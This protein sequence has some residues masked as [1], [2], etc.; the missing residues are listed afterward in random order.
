V[1]LGTIRTN[2]QVIESKQVS[3]IFLESGE[4]NGGYKIRLTVYKLLKNSV[5]KM[6]VFASEQ[7]FMKTKLVKIILSRS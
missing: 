1:E 7:K 6:S 2:G 3:V 5:E 4:K